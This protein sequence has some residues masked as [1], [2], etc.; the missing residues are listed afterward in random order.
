MHRLR[1]GSLCLVIAAGCLLAAPLWAQ[2]EGLPTADDEQF[3]PTYGLGD[4]ILSINLGM[5]IPLFYA[6]GPDGVQDANLS[7]GGTGNLMWGS[8]LN[9]NLAIGGE[10]GGMFAFTPN[11]RTLFMIPLAARATYFLRSYPFELTLSLAAGIN[12]SRLGDNFKT[13][14]IVIPG[15]GLYWNYNAE[16]AFGFDIRYWWVPQFYRGP[17]PP[18]EDS[19]FG[20]FMAITLAALDHF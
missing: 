2:S 12:F 17:E 4:Q 9:N 20:N 8:F 3:I 19:R 10:F 18:Q 15:A 14:P 13:D 1:F 5:F 7:L 11:R 6:G 16:W